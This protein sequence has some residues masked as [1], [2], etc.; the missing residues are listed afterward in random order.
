MG[1]VEAGQAAP[2]AGVASVGAGH[3]GGA[4]PAGAARLARSLARVRNKG[5]DM[6]AV[7]RMLHYGRKFFGHT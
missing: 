4:V 2:S 3:R 6:A 7:I 5:K 1:G